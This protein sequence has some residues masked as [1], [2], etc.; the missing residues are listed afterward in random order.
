MVMTNDD[1]FRLDQPPATE[2]DWRD[3]VDKVL[4][5]RPFEKV[6]VNETRGGLEIQP[7]YAP[8][9]GTSL[10]PVDPHRIAH[11]WDIRQ[12]HQVDDLEACAAAVL[13]DLEH[14]VTSIELAT[15]SATW[16]IDSLRTALTG[17]LLDIAPVALAPHASVDAARALLALIDER[18]DAATSGS[19]L[20]LD[21]IGEFARSGAVGDVGAAAALAAEIAE[22][23][24][25]VVAVTIDTTRY[26]DAGADEVHELA[27]MLASGVATLRALETAGLALDRA[28]ATIGFRV[29]ADGDQFLT[30]A[31]LRAARSLWAS[32]LAA[33]GVDGQ[34]SRFQAVTSAAMFSRRDAEVN[35][36]RSTSAAFGAGVG[37]ADA[38]TVLPFDGTDSA[39]ARRNARNI[40]H[41]LIDESGIN[42]L[43]DPG[44]GSGFVESLTQRLVSAGWV[45][46]QQI[47]AEGGMAASLASGR[48]E[49]VINES[50]EARLGRLANRK[51]PVTGV[52][53]FPAA[54]AATAGVEYDAGFPLRRPAAPF[55]TLRDAADQAGNA[56]IHLAALGSLADHTARS[57]WITNFLAV[58]GLAIDGGETDGASSP[59]E[60]V[61]SFE[62]SDATVAVICSSDAVYA[63][64]AA[65]TAAA[66]K[67][68][69]AAFIALAGHPG[70]LRAELE[71]AGV[72][73][74]FH[75]GVDVLA[76]L[77]ELH[78]RLGITPR[79]A[80][81]SGS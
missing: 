4:R 43:V 24:P 12:R 67:D 1:R 6:L 10:V 66:L 5:G 31:R 45:A 56:R 41:L 29:T 11:G 34:P 32:V 18:G 26:V 20:G 35:M 14:G 81:G 59:I 52:S 80:Q 9:A 42:R 58:G 23:H 61:A 33:C 2:A 48:V 68:A 30:I 79:A 70:D 64:R 21:P 73:A 72:D 69:G 50:W 74:F 60:A 15:P 62:A 13:D 78:D 44:A 3:A 19:W 65:A 40:Q 38:I 49:Q 54:D 51:E 75:V 25:H 53:E 57:T 16:T 8:A 37:G 28:A 77:H 55:E 46:F 39:L 47:E 63:E 71:A 76:A 17:V 7:M 27:W 36:L 22:R